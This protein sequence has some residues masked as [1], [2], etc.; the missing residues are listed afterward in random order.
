[1]TARALL[2]ACLAACASDGPRPPRAGTP[3]GSPAGTVTGLP[4]GTPTAT[5]PAPD[6]VVR[7]EPRVCDDPAP[8][9]TAAF[10]RHELPA[11]P[12]TAHGLYGGGVT[13]AD[14]D[15]DGW[16]DL[17]LTAETGLDLWW[18][19]GDPQAPFAPPATDWFAD[20]DLAFAVGTV[21]VDLDVDGRLDLVV[22]RWGA[23]NA[24]LRNTGTRFAAIT[25]EAMLGKAW[26]TQAATA[27][28]LDA[29]GDLDLF[30][31]GYGPTPATSFD[32]DMAPAD[33][34][35]LYRNDGGAFVDVSDMLS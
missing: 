29:D 2:V 15:G 21:A 31:G 35:E 19:T 20:L 27:A 3:A 7:S 12:G 23:P 17:L 18:G 14:L 4:A 30:F 22:S 6:L 34:A 28:D 24:L 32:P 5:T 8:R 9:A 13:A 26:R 11:L 16:E 33:P 10:D 25:P 1:M